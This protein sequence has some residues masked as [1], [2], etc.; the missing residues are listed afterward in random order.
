MLASMSRRTI[1]LLLTSCLLAT[2]SLRAID[3]NRSSFRKDRHV[4]VIVWDGMRPD[5][6]TEQNTPALW[7]L[8]RSG[9]IFR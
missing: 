2:Q 1:S 9:V 6:V 3:G 7:R 4:V 8:A 5:F